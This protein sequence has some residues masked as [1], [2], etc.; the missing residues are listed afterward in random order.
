MFLE[1]LGSG[2]E[3]FEGI[4]FRALGATPAFFIDVFYHEV[5][6]DRQGSCL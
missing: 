3:D 5:L 4:A 1:R 6:P 2:F